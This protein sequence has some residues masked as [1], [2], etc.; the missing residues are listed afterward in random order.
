MRGDEVITDIISGIYKIRNVIN[1]KF[2]VGSAVGFSHRKSQ[3]FSA[4]NLNEHFN[5]HLQRSWL[6]YGQDN[7]VF[8]II[9]YCEECDLI[10]REQYYLDLYWP[11]GVLYNISPTAGNTLGRKLREETKQKL[12]EINEGENNPRS[13]L[14]WENIKE[15]RKKYFDGFTEKQLAEEYGVSVHG[16]QHVIENRNWYDPNYKPPSDFFGRRGERNGGA[17]L[18]KEQVKSIREEY[19]KGGI[20]QKDLAIKYNVNRMTILRIVNNK[21]W[22]EL[23]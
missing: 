4:L 21:Y 1:G 16:I 19:K 17:K 8:E 22:K 14:I 6:K 3:H 10:K 23:K 13:K 7:F 15:I 2:Y 9:E 20:F 18:T 12:S 5:I 11:L